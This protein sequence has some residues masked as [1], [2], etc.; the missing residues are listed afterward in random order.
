VRIISG[1]YGSGKTEIAVNYAFKLAEM[2]RNPVL[3]D[4]DII[5]PYFRS[6]ERFKALEERGVKLIGSSIKAPGV[7]VPALS[8]EVYSVFD[9]RSLEAVVDVG[10]DKAGADVLK[11]FSDHFSNPEEYDLF[12]VINAYRPSTRTVR[13]I[14][15]YIKMVDSF[16]YN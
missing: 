1:H 13:Q 4:L 6:R 12:I 16:R 10:G 11:R 2:G 8:A 15:E 3:A 5:N 7:D 9:N 14:E